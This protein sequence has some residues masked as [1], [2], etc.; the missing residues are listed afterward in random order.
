VTTHHAAPAAAQTASS[1]ALR[2]AITHL[3][4]PILLGTGMAL[5]YLGGFH[6]P[7][8]HGLKI[9]MVGSTPQVQVLAQTVKNTLGDAVDIQTVR[10]EADA[11][12]LL[13]RQ[14]IVGAYVPDPRHPR[15]LLASAGSDT[16]ALTVEKIVSPIALRQGL[17][18]DVVDV[19]PTSSHD[20]SGQGI[21]FF[22]VALTVGAYSA[23]VAIGAA[24]ARLNVP[25]RGLLGVGAA[26]TIALITTVIAG[27]VYDAIPSRLLPI[28]GLAFLYCAAIVLIGVGLHTF[29]GRFT[30]L[31]VVT[32]FVMLNFTTSG[33]VYAPQLQPGFFAALHHFWI[34]SGL[35]EAGRKLLYFP[36][37]GLRGDVAKIV[38]WLIAGVGLLGLAALTERRRA[39][40]QSAPETAPRPT[41]ATAPLSAPATAQTATPLPAR[42]TAPRPA[43]I[44]AA[45]LAPVAATWG[46]AV[47]P[48][49][50]IYE[51]RRA[52]GEGEELQEIVVA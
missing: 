12:D 50:A 44:A 22:L 19:A 6:G 13:R 3:L 31:T 8:P 34:G 21:F 47:V 35:V 43:P 49:G 16:T 7:S 46:A 27:P 36:E 9:D 48:Q 30:T 4:I 26:A 41:P 38:L 20:P 10:T 52:D 32:L 39:A 45:W 18:L 23:S 33:G 42:A 14:E 51:S 1:P 40:R 5:A 2:H 29:L 11:R 28:G 25:M 17:P 37:L 24:G 15:L